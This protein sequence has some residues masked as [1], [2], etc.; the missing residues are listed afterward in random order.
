MVL[1]HSRSFQ[2]GASDRAIVGRN[3]EVVAKLQSLR[4]G[5]AERLAMSAN[6]LLLW[7]SARRCGSWAQFRAAVEELHLRVD[8]EAEGE[9][10]DSPDQFALPLYQT[11]RFNFQRVGHA[12]FFGGAGDG[13]EWRV[14]PPA[15]A[16]TR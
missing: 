7:M 6:S 9:A 5:T 13:A 1:G 2:E 16:I 3:R 4:Q 8:V 14:T 12:E 10:D 11:L 15:V